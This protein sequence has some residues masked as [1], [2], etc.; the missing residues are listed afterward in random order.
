MKQTSIFCLLL[1]S[2]KG[3]VDIIKMQRSVILKLDQIKQSAIF[4]Y[5]WLQISLFIY[6]FICYLFLVEHFF[7]FILTLNTF[8]DVIQHLA[9]EMY[10]MPCLLH[11][12]H[13]F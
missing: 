2:V 9:V 4:S 11:T 3:L 8:V 12:Q 7:S 6:C 13:A 10:M 5:V 1:F